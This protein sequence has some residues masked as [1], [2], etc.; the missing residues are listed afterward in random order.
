MSSYSLSRPGVYL[1]T[2]GSRSGKSKFAERLV[3]QYDDVAYIATSVITDSEMERRVKKHKASRPNTWKVYEE[4]Y[5]IKDVIVSTDHEI[6]LVDCLTVLGTNYMFNDGCFEDDADLHLFEETEK[7]YSEYIKETVDEI[8]SKGKKVVF[9]TN[10][11]GSG[12]V[13]ESGVSRAFRDMSGRVN[14]IVAQDAEAVWL[15]VSGIPVIIKG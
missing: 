9:V 10:E 1:V 8:Y 11:V 15:V 4:P 2:G 3:S 12:L 14:Q 6:Y 7:K 13:P 5:D